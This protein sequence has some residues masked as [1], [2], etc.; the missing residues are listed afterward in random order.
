MSYLPPDKSRITR[1]R[2]R[3][4]W[5]ISNWLPWN[6]RHTHSALSIHHLHFVCIAVVKLH[7]SRF[8]SN[9]GNEHRP[10]QFGVNKM[11]QLTFSYRFG[12]DF[13]ATSRNVALVLFCPFFA[14]IHKKQKKSNNNELKKNWN[15]IQR[16][17]RFE[18]SSHWCTSIAHLLIHS[19]LNSAQ[20][21]N[22]ISHVQFQ[23]FVSLL[24]LLL[25]L[26]F[27]LSWSLSNKI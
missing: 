26:A 7:N 20:F 9:H 4:E 2:R 21:T 13:D 18:C 11:G 17:L 22:S 1:R 16:S 12:S 25:Q 8:I 23:A 19:R 10:M 6:W 14:R 3:R 27:V 24:L 15:G 5:A